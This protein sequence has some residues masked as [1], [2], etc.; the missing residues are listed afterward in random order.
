MS[1]DARAATNPRTASPESSAD[2]GAG[3]RTRHE[4]PTQA[5]SRL[6]DEAAADTDAL[7]SEL[8]RHHAASDERRRGAV[9]AA[10][11]AAAAARRPAAEA[12]GGGCARERVEQEL[13]LYRTITNITWAPDCGDGILAGVVRLDEAHIARRF[14]IDTTAKSAFDVAQEL[15]ALL[16]SAKDMY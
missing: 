1:A 2:A 12:E 11:A 10:E 6:L 14:A 9:E 3:P 7:K 4:T 13:A 5:V 16:D 8:A 15:W